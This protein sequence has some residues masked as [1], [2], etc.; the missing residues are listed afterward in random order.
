MIDAALAELEPLTFARTAC[1][2]LGKSRATLYRQRNPAPARERP[3]APRAPHPAALSP[4]ERDAL[5][6]ALNADRFADKS[7]ARAWAI[8]LDEGTYL[9]S[10]S[11]MY[12]LLRHGQVRER[13]AQA[14]HP[15]RARPELMADGPDQVWSRD[16][17]KLKGPWRGIWFDLYVMLD[18]FSRKAM[19]WEVHA[20]ENAALAAEF[21][22]C[23]IAASAGIAPR[24]RCR[25]PVTPPAGPRR[26]LRRQPPPVPPQAAPGPAAARQGLDQPATRNSPDRGDTTSK[27]G[28]LISHRV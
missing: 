12:R 24:F 2:L 3:A 8:L 5:L 17:T 10:I 14:A 11:T 27:P 13:R 6:A 26:R 19:R 23:A 18:I 20:T 21:I 25:H 28:R 9:A 15:P 4:A 1:R 22:A 16:I 7:P